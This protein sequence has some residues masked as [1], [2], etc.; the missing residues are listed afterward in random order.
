MKPDFQGRPQSFLAMF[1][2]LAA[3]VV[4]AVLIGISAAPLFTI[5]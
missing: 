4:G 5:T 3:L 2:L 1:M